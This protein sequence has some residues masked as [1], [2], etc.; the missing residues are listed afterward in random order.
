MGGR[1]HGVCQLMDIM[2]SVGF[3]GQVESELVIY[4]LVILV[5]SFE[6]L[7][8]LLEGN[9]PILMSR[10]NILYRKLEEFVDPV[11][12]LLSGMTIA[13]LKC[14]MT[15]SDAFIL[16]LNESFS[17]LPIKELSRQSRIL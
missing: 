6:G 4:V 16:S 14:H 11:T 13:M 9:V 1:G 3:E 7:Y 17:T 10:E 2:A 15:K 12:W 8:L 5:N